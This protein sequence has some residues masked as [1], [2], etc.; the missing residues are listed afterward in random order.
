MKDMETRVAD[1]ILSISVWEG[2]EGSG[3]TSEDRDSE[4]YLHCQEAAR[5]ILA[6]VAGSAQAWGEG[7][8]AGWNDCLLD[9]E[10]RGTP[11]RNPYEADK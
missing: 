5:A 3:V 10:N 6:T 8:G 4:T 11:S 7:Y 2:R 1:L 9:L